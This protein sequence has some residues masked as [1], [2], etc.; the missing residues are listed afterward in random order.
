ML[1]ARYGEMF[2]ED[3]PD[4]LSTCN[5]LIKELKP[6]LS[7]LDR[8]DRLI[9]RTMCAFPLLYR[10][11]RIYDDPTLLVHEKRAKK[12]RASKNT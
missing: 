5:R 9:M 2:T 11:W 8:K 3:Y 7:E 12:Q 10:A 4:V 6:Y 1:S